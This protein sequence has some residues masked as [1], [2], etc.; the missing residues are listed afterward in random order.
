MS[1]ADLRASLAAASEDLS[2]RF[3]AGESV[4]DLV[5]ARSEVIDTLLVQLWQQHI[6]A[7]GAA[8]VAVAS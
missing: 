2:L 6:D 7:F 1:Y 8:L 5:H 3:E 4:V